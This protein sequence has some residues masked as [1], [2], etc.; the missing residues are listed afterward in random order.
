VVASD[1]DKKVLS[2]SDNP[3]SELEFHGCRHCGFG[4]GTPYVDAESLAKFYEGVYYP[5]VKHRRS[6]QNAKF[7]GFVPLEPRSVS[8]ILLVRMFKCFREGQTILDIGP[9]QGRSFRAISEVI[10]GLKYF[11]FEPDLDL[12]SLLERFLG[13]HVFPHRFPSERVASQIVEGRRFDLVLMSHVLEHFNGAD[14]GGVLRNIR[15]L[16]AEDGVLMC[17]VPYCD[18]RQHEKVLASDPSHLSLFSCDSLK[19]A[20]IEAGFN[21][22]FLNTCSEPYDSWRHEAAGQECPANQKGRRVGSLSAW[23]KTVYDLLP[24]APPRR[25]VERLYSLMNPNH[26]ARLLLSND[27]DYGGDRTCL[28]AVASI[29]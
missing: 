21:V 28:R 23:G 1:P 17:E 2:V 6:D 19:M 27:F 15:D 18:W 29:A 22:K 10:P 3:F 25:F 8:Q 9:G 11:A 16:V 5:K 7:P 14:V 13:V 4:W 24:I 20:L 12:S 26:S